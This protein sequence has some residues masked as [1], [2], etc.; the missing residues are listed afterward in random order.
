MKNN[1]LNNWIQDN[2]VL[3]PVIFWG[4]LILIIILFLLSR[5]TKPDIYHEKE[6]GNLIGTERDYCIQQIEEQMRAEDNYYKSKEVRNI[7][8]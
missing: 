5:D 1:K 8:P 3:V 7:I 4:G 6:C 2:K